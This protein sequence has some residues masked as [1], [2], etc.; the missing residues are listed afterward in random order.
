MIAVP[1]KI[2]KEYTMDS[3]SD[4]RRVHK[5]Q[6][7]FWVDS[8]LTGVAAWSGKNFYQGVPTLAAAYAKATASRGDHI[9][10]SPFHAETVTAALTV[11]K[12]GLQII[13]KK[14]GNQRP[15]ITG[16]AAI[17]AIS[18]EAAG[19]S[20]KGIEFG[21]PGTDAQTADINIAAARCLVEDTLHHGSTT[22]NNKVNMI[23]MTSAAS[24]SVI[25]GVRMYNTTV[26]VPAAIAI[27][28]ALSGAEI[29]N[30]FIFDTIGYTNGAI[31]DAA[32]AL[33]LYIHH[34]VLCNRKAG[35]AVLAFANN[36]TGICS[37]NHISGRHTT[38]ASNVTTGTGMD[39][40]E[41]RVTEEASL[42]GGIFPVA[43]SE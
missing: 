34:N 28:G 14:I 4:L 22:S 17:D 42:N 21:I 5:D 1:E 13:G 3:L 19:C 39:F 26:E 40:F 25:D 20:V 43:D 12:I 8:A 37:F 2:R 35:T 38:I 41:N 18:L 32:T 30:S 24:Y 27:E 29:K 6:N 31:A 7:F 36:S 16:N 11:S 9:Y 33:G 15:V 23:T 10:L